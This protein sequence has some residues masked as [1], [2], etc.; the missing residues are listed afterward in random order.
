MIVVLDASAAVEV[1]LKRKS[2]SKIASYSSKADWVIAPMLFISEVT[3]VFW[4][5]FKISEL[6]IEIC[7]RCLEQAIALPDEYFS[8]KELYREA[9]MLSCTA[10]HPVYNGILLTLDNKLFLSGLY[11][12]LGS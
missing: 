1:V 10:D 6:P 4:K 5:Y 8:E 2:A 3:N 7:E 12:S 11:K 9:F